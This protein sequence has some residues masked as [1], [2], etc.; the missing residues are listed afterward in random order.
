MPDDRKRAIVQA[1]AGAFN[2]AVF[3]DLGAVLRLRPLRATL[4]PPKRTFREHLRMSP[5]AVTPIYPGPEGQPDL[6][7][8]AW[9]RAILLLDMNAFFASIEQRDFPKLRDKPVAVTNGTRG[10]CII[11]CSYE[12]R[13]YGVRTGMRLPEARARCPG[14]IQRPSRPHQ[15]AE[16]SMQIMHA[17]RDRVS[18][19]MEVFS[20]DEAFLDVRGVQ[21]LFGS[22][23]A[24]ALRAQQVVREVSGLS[25]S[26]GVAGDRST[27]KYAAELF[28]PG[29][30]GVIPP[31]EAR[32]RLAD[33][34][35]DALC[36]IGSRTRDY[37][38]RFG[39]RTCGDLAR[40][41]VGV[42]ARRFGHP[43][44]RMWLM[45][46]GLD[47]EPL[48]TEAR[49]PQ[50]LGHGKVLPPNTTDRR[51]LRTFLR[52]MSEKLAQR[53]RRHELEARRYWIGLRLDH[54]WV[55]AEKSVAYPVADGRIL[56]QL[57]EEVLQQHWQGQ[58]AHQ[59]QVTALDPKPCLQQRD[60]FE[61]RELPERVRNQSLQRVADDINARYG[62]FMLAPA[63]LL[64]RS[65]M[66]DVI[67]PAWQPDG[68]RKSV[69]P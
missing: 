31:W 49:A 61:R 3:G 25:C 19:V 4:R 50:S 41:P 54:E 47:S 22:P 45:C 43:G 37:L 23:V 66:P 32:Q 59:V 58:P 46:Q 56:F 5:S 63:P 20:V 53:L 38:A 55:G 36:G 67:A 26:V 39:V 69:E 11:T 51:T 33:V 17:L 13:R 9:P 15:Y 28:K 7:P 64:G 62:A 16:V 14:L 29:G 57:C 30:I 42:L 44:R 24:I 52:H 8:L 35:V 21:R 18:P 2:Q 27:A 48:H 1:L 40:L 6:C 12:A 34:P 65:D 10:T 68:V 60:L